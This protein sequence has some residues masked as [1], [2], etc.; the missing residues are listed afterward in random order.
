MTLAILIA[1]SACGHPDWWDEY[2]YQPGAA[3]SSILCRDRY[4]NCLTSCRAVYADDRFEAQCEAGC[5][6]DFANCKIG[7]R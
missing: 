4:G 6:D 5:A 7:G 1:V 3:T 2:D